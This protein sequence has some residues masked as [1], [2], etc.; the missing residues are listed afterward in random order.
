MND[1]HPSN[2]RAVR[3]TIQL[4]GLPRRNAPAVAFETGRVEWDGPGREPT[5]IYAR[6]PSSGLL[7]YKMGKVKAK[8][9]RRTEFH[10]HRLKPTVG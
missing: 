6:V 8:V 7:G 2:D 5:T 10:R 3:K 1:I 9:V 4:T